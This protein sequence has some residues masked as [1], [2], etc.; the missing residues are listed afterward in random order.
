VDKEIFEMLKD[1][2]FSM[3]GV[4]NPNKVVQ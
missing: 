1:I 4:D 2:Y 3:Q